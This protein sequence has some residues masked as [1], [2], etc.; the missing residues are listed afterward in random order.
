[1]DDFVHAPQLLGVI[2]TNDMQLETIFHALNALKIINPD[3]SL[4]IQQFKVNIL[5]K[6]RSLSQAVN[7]A[8]LYFL[9]SAPKSLRD[10][11]DL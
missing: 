10:N 2:M 4:E 6:V 11:Y 5:S 1:M 7:D 9:Q 8:E 3:K